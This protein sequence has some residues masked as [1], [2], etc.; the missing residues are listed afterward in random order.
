MFFYEGYS[1]PVCKKPFDSSDDIV[2]C[3]TCG[4]PHHRACW[5]QEGHCH[6]EADHGTDRQ[7]ARGKKP[8]QTASASQAEAGDTRPCPH[9][10]QPNPS[11]AEFCSR[12]GQSTGAEEWHTPQTPPVGT[13]RPYGEYSPFHVAI[14]PMGG[15]SPEEE[16]ED[17]PA[18]ELAAFVG[19]N[20]A[21]YLPRFQKMAKNGSKCH[22]NWAA[23]LLTPYWLLYRK[24]YLSGILVLV[25]EIVL[26]TLMGYVQYGFFMPFL[27]SLPEQMTQ[28]QISEAIFSNERMTLL[29]WVWILSLVVRLLLHLLVG[30]I[31]NRLYLY[32][33]V[34]RIN[35]LKTKDVHLTTHDI[36]VGGGVSFGLAIGVYFLLDFTKVILLSLL[37]I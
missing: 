19:P 7:W 25:V 15:V 6:F 14:D 34:S 10:G 21:Y 22:W 5:Q 12:C 33:T 20:A 9:C 2:A 35:K 16:I 8:P 1:C 3:P 11:F 28:L 36:A 26:S 32:T 30:L 27:D 18:Q 37:L 23:F 4:A 13:G 31:G 17:I 29:L 24:Q